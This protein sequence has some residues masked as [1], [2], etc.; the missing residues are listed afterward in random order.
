M[1]RPSILLLVASLAAWP[2]GAGEWQRY[3]LPEQGTYAQRYLPSAG[4]QPWPVVVFLHGSGVRPE[5]WMPILAPVAEDVGAAL[6]LPRST[7]GLGFGVGGDDEAIA[8]AL[9]RLRAEVSVDEQRIA[10]AGH[11]SGGAYAVVLAYAR[12]SGFSGVFALASPYR[13][14]LSLADPDYTA[15][16]RLYYGTLDP[17]FQASRPAMIGQLRRLGVPMELVTAP[18]FGHS[19]VPPGTYEEGFRFLLD[20]R[21]A[22]A[23]GC[24][25]SATRLCLRDG[26]YAVEATWTDAAGLS[27]AARVG[28]A[29]TSESGLLTFFSAE[30]WELQVKV[31]DG[32]A[33][34]DHLWVFA[35]GTTD[36]G[37]DLQV[38]ELASGRIAAYSHA[39]G[40]PVPPILDV[41]A[42]TCQ[43]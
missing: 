33:L 1:S 12:R 35:A 8:A 41:E 14:V 19:G 39:A 10:V 13:T 31:L 23:G 29:R 7:D 4:A 25:P 42:F 37:F 36:V 9:D 32:C 3:D 20:Q 40:Q 26:A 43:P 15:P 2:A 38:T 21:Y 17:N 5:D 34:N 27:D 11:S 24:Q 16:L 30:N 28:G 6:V 18:G 22:T